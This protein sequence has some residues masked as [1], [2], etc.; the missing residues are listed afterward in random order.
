MTDQPRP[1]RRKH[2]PLGVKLQVALDEVRRLR[3][4]LG[5]PFEGKFHFD[6]EPALALRTWDP[7]AQDTIPPA[8]DPK[9]LQLLLESEHGPKTNGTAATTAGS[10]KNRIAKQN[11]RDG[12]TK[13]GP[14]RKIPNPGFPKPP[15]GYK[16]Q[17][18]KRTF[19]K[20]RA[21]A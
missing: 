11:R 1:K 10:D 15:E 9:A 2:I 14:K 5:Y 8:N 12:L 19:A 7:E 17:W 20:K 3:R 18:A 16:H 21:K 6:H 13:Q 4:L